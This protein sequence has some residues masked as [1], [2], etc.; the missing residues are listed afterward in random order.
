MLRRDGAGAA[1]KRRSA[2]G[3]ETIAHGTASRII[4]GRTFVLDD[5]REVR[6][7]AIEVP[8]LPLP[9]ESDAAPGGAAAK[10]RARR[11]LR[12][13]RDRAQASR[14]RRR[15]I[16]TGGVVAYAFTVRDG[17]EHSVQADLVAAGLARVAA[18]AGSRACAVELL[19]P[20]KRR[21]AGQAWPLG[22][23]VL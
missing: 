5:G 4:D 21:A 17:V 16:A 19:E 7:A 15:P 8:P 12:G 9:Q 2:C 18:R 10:R 20:R 11:A 1:R 3:G 14:S 6:L 23:F 13:R 22:Q